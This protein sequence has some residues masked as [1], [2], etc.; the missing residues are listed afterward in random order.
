MRGLTHCATSPASVPKSNLLQ[1]FCFYEIIT[2]VV[3]S[4]RLKKKPRW[5]DQQH[6]VNKR[7]EWKW[8]QILGMPTP[9]SMFGNWETG[10]SIHIFQMSGIICCLPQHTST[11]SWNSGVRDPQPGTVKWGTGISSSETDFYFFFFLKECNIANMVLFGYL[12]EF[13]RLSLWASHEGGKHP[14]I[15]PVPLIP[16]N[17]CIGR[18]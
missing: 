16:S 17:G 6:T 12:L 4:D 10:P 14:I 18:C 7:N 13:V 11:G 3:I 9:E 1:F 8:G 5:F 15:W 2:V